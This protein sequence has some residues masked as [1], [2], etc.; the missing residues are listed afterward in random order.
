MFQLTSLQWKSFFRSAALAGNLF[1]KIMTWFW[2][3]YLTGMALLLGF[4]TPLMLTSEEFGIED[5]F[6][7][8]NKNLIYVFVYW[9]VIRYIFQKIPILNIRALLLTPLR[10]SKIIRFAMNRTIFSIFNMLSFFYLIPFSIM[11]V[12]NEDLGSY[13][14]IQLLIW[15][16]AIATL[17][18]ITN[19]LN[20]LLNKQDKLVIGIGVL[21]VSIKALEYFNV[22][23]LTIYSE[24]I[25][26]SFYINPILVI[27]PITVLIYTYYYVYN[28][29]HKNLSIDTGLSLKVKEATKDDFKWLDQY[30]EMAK[31]L[32][33]DLRLIKRTKRARSTVIMGAFFALYGLIFIASEEVYGN[34]GA[35]FGL[36]FSTGGFMFTFCGM[37]PSWDSKH[38]PL[39][40][41]QNITYL[42]YIKSKWYLGFT[43]TIIMTLVGLLIYSYFGLFYALGIIC[44]GLYNLGVNSYITLWAGAF[45]KT[46]IDLDS[47]KNAFGDTKSFNTK[48][49]LMIIP[50]MV[51]PMLLFYFVSDSY[52]PIIGAVSVGVFG[53][54][55]I[56]FRN[57][58]FSMIVKTYKSEKHSTLSAYKQTN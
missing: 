37:V 23:D 58:A 55:G 11:L 28:Y 53:I 12:V 56:V 34:T 47:A 44:S 49:M 4:G 52:D 30:G 51:L 26:Y 35:F 25:F 2:I 33:N 20:I 3:I 14:G 32:R 1:S 21:F 16:I 46:A 9:V 43:G 15:N 17:V 42:D 24:Q 10:K 6:L 54:L 45:N 8:I 48:T 5:P 40:M 19:F 41:C 13:D 57:K 31:F 36:F 27:A 50:Q 39:M 22:V 29:Y 38:Y 7:F 18:Y